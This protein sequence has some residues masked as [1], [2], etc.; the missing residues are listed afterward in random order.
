MSPTLPDDLLSRLAHVVT[1][2]GQWD[3][4]AVF[5]SVAVAAI[6]IG[7]RRVHRV[8]PGVLVAVA[9]GIY[10]GT[11]DNFTAPVIGDIPEGLPPLSLAMPWSRIA[12]LLVPGAVIAVVGFAEATA[13]SRT[14]AVLDRERWDA[15]KELVAI[16]VAN[17]AAGV[18]GGFPVGGS[19]SRSSV[20]QIAGAQSRWAGA[21]TGIAVLAFMPFANILAS[22]PKAVL[23]TVVLVA[24][25]P[26]IRAVD[27]FRLWK[28]TRGQAVV[29]I[30]TAGSTL[31]LAPRI[32]LGVMLGVAAAGA[33]H[34]HR[35]SQRIQI[36]GVAHRRRAHAAAARRALLRLG[37]SALRDAW[38]PNSPR[39][40]TVRSSSWISCGSVAST[41]PA[42]RRCRRSPRSFVRLISRSACRACL[43][44]PQDCSSA[45]AASDA[46]GRAAGR[47]VHATCVL[48]DEERPMAM[49][50]QRVCRVRDRRSRRVGRE[51]RRCARHRSDD[52][53]I[54]EHARA[55]VP[56]WVEGD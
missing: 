41:T 7:G 19:F 52:R 55:G 3:L 51:G 40:E 46:C 43:R 28:V 17:M 34:L 38:P 5:L 25:I 24:I 50:E 35:E 54:D 44:M 15:S 13:I 21:F 10:I 2:P 47:H 11:G 1:N 12:E 30:F 33:L 22:L 4:Q 23:G 37:R 36:P 39:T 9:L 56:L 53:L 26:L 42:C 6:L 16:G 18:S 14:L 49:T 31:I 20:N 29:A 48:F 45:S 27:I 32:D 8:F